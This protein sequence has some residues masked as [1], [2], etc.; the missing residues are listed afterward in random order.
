MPIDCV[1]SPFL[2]EIPEGLVT[3]REGEAALTE[4]EEASAWSEVH[5][6]FTI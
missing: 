4:D 5:K 3:W 2:A 1:P 6:M